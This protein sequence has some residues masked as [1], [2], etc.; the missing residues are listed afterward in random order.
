MAD[1]LPQ[2]PCKTRANHPGTGRERRRRSDPGAIAV[3]GG[4]RVIGTASPRHHEALRALGVES[5]DYS[6]PDLSSRIREL[7]SRGVG[8]VFDHLGPESAK[9]S[10]GL[11]DRGGTLICYG[12]AADLDK[13][14]ALVPVFLG[15]LARLALWT[16]LPNGRSAPFYDF[17]EGMLIG[18]T[19]ARRRRRADLAEVLELLSSGAIKPI[20]ATTFPLFEAQAALEHAEAR[21]VFGKVVIVP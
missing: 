11:L 20:V 12:I 13:T 7:S 19:A 10:F 5:V 9:N 1:A 18:P 15:L 6:A 4:I 8:A 21:G 16:A 2:R 3:H 17:W 14:T